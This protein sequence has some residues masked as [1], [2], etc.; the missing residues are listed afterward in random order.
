MKIRR[1]EVNEKVG[2]VLTEDDWGGFDS[3]PAGYTL[4][5][6]SPEDAEAQAAF[7]RKMEEQLDLFAFHSRPVARQLALPG[8]NSQFRNM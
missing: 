8:V 2:D 7:R 1:C 3:F 6:D 5:F 4:G